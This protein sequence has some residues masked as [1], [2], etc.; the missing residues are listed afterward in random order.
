[1]TS[2]SSGFPPYPLT[3][4]EV[5][6]EFTTDLGARY[7]LYFSDAAG[8]FEG[9]EFAPHALMLGLM[10]L[11]VGSRHQYDPRVEATLLQFVKRAFADRR[12]ILVYVCDQTDNLQRQR[13]RLFNR[14][15]NK[16]SQGQYLKLV[17]AEEE[18]L[19]ASLLYHRDNPFEE[20]LRA[21]IPEVRDKL[22]F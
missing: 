19:Y 11:A 5:G 21:A 15:F 17:L 13:H 2:D 6:D 8:Y 12:R 18:T 1:M 3:Q 16:Y 7:V 14:L 9:Y 10:R 22:G 20:Q 4:S